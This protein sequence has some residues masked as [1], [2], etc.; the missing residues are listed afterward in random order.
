[1]SV[2]SSL[3]AS[4]REGRVNRENPIEG[5]ENHVEPSWGQ[6]A[7]GLT[8]GVLPLHVILQTQSSIIFGVVNYKLQLQS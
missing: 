1:M 3:P 6:V 8:L 5:R 7:R 2:P 4:M